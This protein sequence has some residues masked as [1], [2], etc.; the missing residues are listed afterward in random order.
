MGDANE[1]CD[2]AERYHKAALVLSKLGEAPPAV[3][4]VRLKSLR[5]RV[6]ADRGKR[7]PHSHVEALII[8]S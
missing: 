3:E 8:T 7:S 1:Y 5:Q 2:V 4:N 6:E